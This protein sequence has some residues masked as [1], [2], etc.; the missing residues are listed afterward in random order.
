MGNYFFVDPKIAY[1]PQT[2]LDPK[3]IDAL[4]PEFLFGRENRLPPAIFIPGENPLPFEGNHRLVTAD[5]LDTFV[6]GFTPTDRLDVIDP[7]EFPDHAEEIRI[8]NR[9]MYLEFQRK[10]NKAAHAETL[11][12]P[13]FRKRLGIN[14]LQDLL[15]FSQETTERTLPGSN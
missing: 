3:K 11:P 8:L 10:R 4:L 9:D 15:Q 7:K 14:S 2:Y 13:E 6:F 12:I 1:T 5:V